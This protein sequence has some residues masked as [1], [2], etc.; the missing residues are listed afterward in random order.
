[1]VLTRPPLASAG[2]HTGARPAPG[3]RCALIAGADPRIRRLLRTVLEIGGLEVAEATS[4]GEVL[5]RLAATA[6]PPDV[7]ILDVALPHFSGVATLSF[8][9]RDPR[10]AGVPV[11][12]LTSFG[13]PPEHTRY[14]QSGATA[15]LSK[16]FSAQR[17]LE[18]V[19]NISAAGKH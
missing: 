2:R 8:M 1:M 5:S 4:Q 19:R 12:V 10:L 15:V 6:R 13:D 11:V 7:V 3:A 14:R 17:L 18:T 16:P 9:R